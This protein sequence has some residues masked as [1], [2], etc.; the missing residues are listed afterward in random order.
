MAGT[1]RRYTGFGNSHDTPTCEVSISNGGQGGQICL[2]LDFENLIIP[3]AMRSDKLVALEPII[4][5]LEDNFGIVIFRRAYA[6]WAERKFGAYQRELQ[7]LGVE[8]IQVPRQSKRSI[9][10]SADILLTADAVECLLIRPFI[11]TFAIVS[12]DSD[13]GPL[14]TKLKSHGKTV[15]VIGPDEKSTAKHVINLADRFKFFGDI[16]EPEATPVEPAPGRLQTPQEAIVA[17]LKKSGE[18]VESANLKRR[19][20]TTKGHEGFNEKALGFKS[21]TAFLMAIEEVQVVRRSDLRIEARLK[22]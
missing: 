1:R 19:L 12:G 8:M 18:P 11:D 17:L 15:V 5:F 13:V 4:D 22:K 14:I 3:F 16:V 20:I 7:N 9:K 6:D 21:W 2:L 10:N